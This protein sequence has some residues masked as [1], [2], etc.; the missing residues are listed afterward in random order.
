[1]PPAS[2]AAS[3]SGSDTVRPDGEVGDV[4]IYD[5]AIAFEVPLVRSRAAPTEV[6]L[7]A[8]Y[9]GCAERDLE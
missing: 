2:T 1:M 5:E 4:A 7:V 3:R 9:Q 6:T 8:R